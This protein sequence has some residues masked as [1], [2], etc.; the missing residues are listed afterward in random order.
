MPQWTQLA[1]YDPELHGPPG[2]GKGLTT[3]AF[4]ASLGKKIMMVSIADLESKFWER[5]SSA[6]HKPVEDSEMNLCAPSLSCT[7]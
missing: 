2:T 1:G 4:A 7:E 3:E 5:R 6:A